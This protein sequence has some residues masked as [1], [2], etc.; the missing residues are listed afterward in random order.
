MEGA[1]EV[2]G[3]GKFK[4]PQGVR[5]G[6]FPE[7]CIAKEVIRWG[8]GMGGG[9]PPGL[10]VPWCFGL[11]ALPACA[12]AQSFALSIF[13]AKPEAASPSITSHPRETSAQHRKRGRA[14]R[15]KA[16]LTPPRA[17]P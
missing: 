16:V 3:Q 13:P 2:L 15:T 1:Q 12:P 8:A 4:E 10:L 7:I 6:C 5:Q 11:G 9:V 14:P 17:V